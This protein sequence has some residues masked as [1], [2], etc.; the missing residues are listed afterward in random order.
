MKDIIIL[1]KAKKNILL[2]GFTDITA[3][4]EVAQALSPV[5]LT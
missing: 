1:E 4:A 3:P 2:E 5:N